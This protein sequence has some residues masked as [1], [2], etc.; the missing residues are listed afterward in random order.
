MNN[1]YWQV[2]YDFLELKG[3]LLIINNAKYIIWN[4][5]SNKHRLNTSDIDSI[6]FKYGVFNGTSVSASLL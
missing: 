2:Y 4:N 6:W 3:K 5:G 1:K